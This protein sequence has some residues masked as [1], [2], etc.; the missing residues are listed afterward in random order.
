MTDGSPSSPTPDLDPSS[1]RAP[2]TRWQKFRRWWASLNGAAILAFATALAALVAAFTS[3]QNLE[4]TRNQNKTASDSAIS[5][6]FAKATEQL[7]SDKLNSRVAAVYL[8]ERL[9]SDSP[10]DARSIVE[11]LSA[12]ARDQG[13]IQ[14]CEP[15]ISPK[16]GLR[17]EAPADIEAVLTTLGRMSR[18]DDI[19]DLSGA[20][21]PG[22]DLRDADLSKIDFSGASFVHS[23][24]VNVDMS[25]S[26]FRHA[27]FMGSNF[28]RANLSNATLESAELFTAKFNA[29]TVTGAHLNGS[30]LTGADLTGAIGL[31]IAQFKP[32]AP[33]FTPGSPFNDEPFVYC[34][35]GGTRWP[36]GFRPPPC[37][38]KTN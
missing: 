36:A 15:T 4:I 7:A 20:C 17:I 37:H 8:L 35:E 27:S 21:F 26:V 34:T 6:R 32:A 18:G 5:E 31:T 2:S 13:S 11:V 9:A 10:K 16:G 3:V 28:D 19:V 29:T 14:K 12:F 33:Y 1:A 24:F 23:S 38:A 22:V 25:S 30:N